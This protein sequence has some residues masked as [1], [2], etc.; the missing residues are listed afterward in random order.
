[1]WIF[2]LKSN[3]NKSKMEKKPCKSMIIAHADRDKKHARF[4]E[5]VNL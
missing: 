1:M 2:L 5:R 3:K 4:P